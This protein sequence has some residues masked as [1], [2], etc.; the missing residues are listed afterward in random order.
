M[1]ALGPLLAMAN[2]CARVGFP[3]S[4]VLGM[5][6]VTISGIYR[7]S[8]VFE[9][10]VVDSLRVVCPGQAERQLLYIDECITTNMYDTGFQFYSK[11]SVLNQNK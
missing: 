7:S 1:V 8:F 11:I 9:R 5:D 2:I 10:G 3:T 6:V 4:P